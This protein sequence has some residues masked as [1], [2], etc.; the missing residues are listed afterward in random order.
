MNNDPN[1]AQSKIKKGK[2]LQ[3]NILSSNDKE[4]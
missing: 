2:P 4:R 1:E 3:E